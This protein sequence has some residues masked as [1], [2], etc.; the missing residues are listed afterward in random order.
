MRRMS[1]LLLLSAL[2]LGA[3]LAQAEP[4]RNAGRFG[5]GMR[6]GPGLDYPLIHVLDPGEVADRGGCNLT[7]R[8]CLMTARAKVGWVDI[9]ALSQPEAA[10]ERAE[11]VR[12]LRDGPI[13]S[14]PLD[15]LSRPLPR[16]IL[17][18]VEGARDRPPGAMA[19]PS[20]SV[21][22]IPVPGARTPR[23]LSTFEPIRNVTGRE[24]NLRAGPGTQNV[25]VGRLRPGE[26]GRVDVCDASEQWCR[27]DAPGIGPAWVRMTF[28]GL[29]RL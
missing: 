15:G 13:G 2:G 4:L 25:V 1:A 8:W 20:I 29:R 12:P 3:P 7:G 22:P 5:V 23:L 27:I 28:M 17:D 19:L 6:A 18:A 10:P 11:A 14:L 9:F 24:V 16:A 26:G 21:H